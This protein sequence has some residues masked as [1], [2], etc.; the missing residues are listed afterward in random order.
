MKPFMNNMSQT[1]INPSGWITSIVLHIGVFFVL[2]NTP[3]LKEYINPPSFFTVHLINEETSPT[4]LHKGATPDETMANA[5]LPETPNNELMPNHPIQQPAQENLIFKQLDKKNLV[6]IQEDLRD[7]NSGKNQVKQDILILP[8]R[9]P[10]KLTVVN[11]VKLERV[12]GKSN[13]TT[14]TATHAEEISSNSPTDKKNSKGKT[15]VT[16]SGKKPDKELIIKPSINLPIKSTSVDKAKIRKAIKISSSSSMD[17]LVFS[18]ENVSPALQEESSPSKKNPTKVSTARTQKTKPLNKQNPTWLVVDGPDEEIAAIDIYEKPPERTKATTN[19]K[20][21]NINKNEKS[22][23]LPARIMSPL[24]NE[25]IFNN[26]LKN[27]EKRLSSI[28]QNKNHTSDVK[29]EVNKNLLK[30]WG[31]SVRNDVV[32]RTLGSKLSR[33]VKIVLRISKTGEL[34]TL[35]IIGSLSV[36]K[37]IKNF[38]STIKTSG[39]FPSAPD[40][41]KLDYVNFPISFRSSG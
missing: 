2:L 23:I 40:G 1:N 20:I 16:P 34:L 22:G 6:S 8:K 26:E 21:N 25:K 35:K 29:I 9:K 32:K 36:D 27:H 14:L 5:S 17:D 28:K 10:N 3:I 13:N 33:D 39:N 24:P 18:N 7:G 41:L 38:I 12:N 19:N 30:T 11:N 4:K 37:N 31:V 15:S